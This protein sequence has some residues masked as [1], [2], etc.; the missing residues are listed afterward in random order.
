M[1]FSLPIE[2]AGKRRF[3]ITEAQ[4]LADVAR[5]NLAT[6]AWTVRAKVR[7]ALVEYLIAQRS[8]GL[9]QNEERVRTEQVKM[10][11]QRLAV[12][13]IPRPEVDSARI[14]Q[15]QTLLAVRT[16][17]GRQDQARV[18]LAAA[19]GVPV[20]A[21]NNVQVAWPE[22]DDLPSV[23]SL[24]PSQIQEDAVLNRIDIHQALAQYAAADAALRLEAARQYPNLDL[25]SSWAYE[26]GAHLFSLDAGSILPIRNQNQGPIAE[27]KA[28]REEIAANFVSVQTAGIAAS[29]RALANYKSALSE[30]AQ[31]RQLLWQSRAQ[32]QATQKALNR[33]RATE[34]PSTARSYR[35]LSTLWRS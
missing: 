4:R 11:E 22:F 31:A 3:R 19:I 20:A 17:E 2:T 33:D 9:L 13:M 21:L 15:T 28:R 23:A 32:E 25:G 24:T 29:E 14:Q 12:G 5:W 1:G 35:Q 27:A 6:A 10:L 26:E 18:S 30:M 8:L 16:A 34:L 7:G